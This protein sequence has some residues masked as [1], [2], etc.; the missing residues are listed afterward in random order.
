MSKVLKAGFLAPPLIVS[1]NWKEKKRTQSEML[2]FPFVTKRFMDKYV[3]GE[4][5]RQEGYKMF[6]YARL[7]SLPHFRLVK[8]GTK[9]SWEA[10]LPEN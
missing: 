2:F 3:L 7:N 9:T 10:G 1:F 5:H 6:N 4:N 8:H